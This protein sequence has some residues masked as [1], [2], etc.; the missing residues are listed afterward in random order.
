MVQRFFP[1]G[2]ILVE[3]VS[4]FILHLLYH[5]SVTL[6]RIQPEYEATQTELHMAFLKKALHMMEKRWVAA[7]DS[8][9]SKTPILTDE[10]QGIT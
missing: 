4:P 8:L 1:G 6:K 7:G 3:Q 5:A 10:N 2:A 9:A